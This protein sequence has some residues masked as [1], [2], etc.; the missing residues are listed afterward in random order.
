MS[1][2]AVDFQ[3]LI[4]ATLSDADATLQEELQG[5][6]SFYWRLHAR[7]PYLELRYWYVRRDLIRVAM[8]CVTRQVDYIRRNQNSART[9]VESSRQDSTM[10]ASSEENGSGEANRSSESQFDDETNS[11]GSASSNASRNS[12]QSANGEMHYTDTG[13]GLSYASRHLHSETE[14]TERG[15]VETVQDDDYA[16]IHDRTGSGYRSGL[17]SQATDPDAFGINVGVF[18]QSVTI[19][20]GT[21]W[22]TISFDLPIPFDIE[23]ST[24]TAGT[25]ATHDEAT[26]DMTGSL[27]GDKIREQITDINV[28][29]QPKRELHMTLTD[30]PAR[31]HSS[32]SEF[33]A[34]VVQTET[35]TADSSM[36]ANAA[37]ASNF[38]MT[39]SGSGTSSS[40]GTSGSS[41]L[42]TSTRTS[43][44]DGEAS[45]SS[46]ATMQMNALMERLN[47]RF[48]HLQELWENANAMIQWL[49][50]QRLALPA[51]VIQQITIQYPEGMSANIS[52]I[53]N[54]YLVAQ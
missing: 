37:S 3:N 47:Q 45:R 2:T 27:G 11:T 23:K 13:T 42:A 19:E 17:T 15:E 18:T 39:G 48:L 34:N 31:A 50:S 46:Q 5:K 33:T 36:T 1:V 24:Y 54:Q 51:Y 38:E 28:L 41:M 26:D 25:L 16:L 52:Q 32:H 22:G 20:I 4:V 53:A 29:T 49:E 12:S 7:A 21:P 44:S 43:H 10:S 35:A 6:M 14:T 30:A 8:A 40:E 9:S